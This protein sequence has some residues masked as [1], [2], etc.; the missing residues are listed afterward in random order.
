MRNNNLVILILFILFSGYSCNK[1]NK[2]YNSDYYIDE[3][4]DTIAR[5]VNWNSVVTK[6]KYT[7]KD[8]LL[9]DK[10]R[11]NMNLSFDVIFYSQDS[12]DLLSKI[13]VEEYEKCS[14][15]YKSSFDFWKKYEHY[16]LNFSYCVFDNDRLKDNDYYFVE[17][18]NN[19]LFYLDGVRV[20]DCEKTTLGYYP[21]NNEE[22][23]FW[24]DKILNK[25]QI[26]RVIY[27]IKPVLLKK[28][29]KFWLLDEKGQ[30][31]TYYA[32]VLCYRSLDNYNFTFFYHI[33]KEYKYSFDPNNIKYN[34][35]H[36]G[37]TMD[38][39]R[40][41]WGNSN[42]VIFRKDGTILWKYSMEKY[43]IFENGE[44]IIHSS[45]DDDDI[46]Q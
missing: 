13:S 44:L 41:L 18:A 34:K 21:Y 4:N 26:E 45:N 36:K 46:L 35:V 43:L 1:E 16:L 9:L 11:Q 38:E 22:Y 25:E 17:E 19:K 27:T 8:K 23:I 5:R 7:S 12:Y 37:M 40:R 20:R 24:T 28:E 14:K 30:P 6:Y 2:N 15:L 29:V 39:C 33:D 10:I 3:Y 32:N 42:E 31:N